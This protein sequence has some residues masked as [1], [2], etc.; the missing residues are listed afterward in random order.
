MMSVYASVTTVMMPNAEKKKAGYS[1]INTEMP[2]MSN[3]FLTRSPSSK[4]KNAKNADMKK[5]RMGKCRL[6]QRVNSSAVKNRDAFVAV[7]PWGHM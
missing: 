6:P 5:K 7:S 4:Q 2:Q 3:C 1:V